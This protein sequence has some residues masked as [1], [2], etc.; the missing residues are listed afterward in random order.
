MRKCIEELSL[1]TFANIIEGGKTENLSA[2]R[3]CSA[4]ILLSCLPLDPRGGEIKEYPRDSG[5]IEVE[6]DRRRTTHDPQL[7]R[8]M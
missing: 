8:S 3:S 2:K 4:W 5:G 7:L 6:Y 1:P